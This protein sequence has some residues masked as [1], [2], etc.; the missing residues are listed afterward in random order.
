VAGHL[1]GNVGRLPIGGIVDAN[2]EQLAGVEGFFDGIEDG[3]GQSFLADAHV[4]I[5]PV[6]QRSKMRALLRGQTRTHS[7]I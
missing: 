3:V 1:V 5:V 6:S 4:G 2:F 7:Q